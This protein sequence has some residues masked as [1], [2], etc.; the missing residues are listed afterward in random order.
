M[1]DDKDKKDAAAD[2]KKA[3]EAAKK[4]R[5]TGVVWMLVGIPIILL[6]VALS[7]SND[8]SFGGGRGSHSSIDPRTVGVLTLTEEYP[9]VPME[10]DRD[11]NCTQ[12][13]ITQ[14]VNWEQSIN[15]R[16]VRQMIYGVGTIPLVDPSSIGIITN[17]SFRLLRGQFVQTAKLAYVKY[18]GANPPQ[19]WDRA[20][21]QNE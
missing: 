21:L 17:M 8:F 9:A 1:A 19:G 6:L 11:Q 13:I 2:A 5:K 4:D 3:E 14:G 18:R 15:G 7:S 10:I 16:P 20:A 12:A